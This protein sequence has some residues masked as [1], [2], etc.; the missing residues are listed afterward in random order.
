MQLAERDMRDKLVVLYVLDKM[1]VPLST[2]NL[3][4][5]CTE[6]NDWID[7][8]TLNHTIHTLEESGFIVESNVVNGKSVYTL[9]SDGRQCVGFFSTRIPASIRDEVNNV[10]TERRLHFKKTQE[11]FSDYSKNPDGTYTVIL[12]IDNPQNLLELKLTT[13]TKENAEHF[14]KNWYD[15]AALAYEAIYDTL[16][17]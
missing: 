6:T 11:Y 1:E 16:M 13:D 3:I 10:V 17:E 14:V 7:Y 4:E 12:R 9:T 5:I 15:R 2:E 8:Y